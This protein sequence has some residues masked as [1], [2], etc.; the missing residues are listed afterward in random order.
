[1]GNFLDSFVS[2]GVN[3]QGLDDDLH[4]D[5]A[6]HLLNGSVVGD[7][8]ESLLWGFWKKIYFFF[9]EVDLDCSVNLGVVAEDTRTLFGSGVVGVFVCEFL[10]WGEVEGHVLIGGELLG[11]ELGGNQV[12]GLFSVVLSDDGLS[13][14]E[15]Q[16]V[17]KRVGLFFDFFIYELHE[18]VVD[19]EV[20]LL[21]YSIVHGMEVQFEDVDFLGA[22][23][24]GNQV[25]DDLSLFGFEVH[26]GNFFNVGNEFTNQ[27][28][29]LFD[30]Q[31]GT[32]LILQVIIVQGVE[33]GNEVVSHQQLLFGFER[34][35][36]LIR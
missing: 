16:E 30:I 11:S 32:L 6:E 34:S 2:F 25:A 9:G 29:N 3:S 21:G 15:R 33:S 14:H 23:G 31:F 12:G 22:E 18:V 24:H 27:T 7:D 19:V 35:L 5:L 10:L 1:M 26:Q 17:A 8:F 36:H 20:V 28:L 13:N 4:V